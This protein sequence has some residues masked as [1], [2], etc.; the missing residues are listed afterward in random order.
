MDI[1]IGHGQ[2]FVYDQIENLLV[3]LH[4][5]RG[6]QVACDLM[7]LSIPPPLK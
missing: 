6:L 1:Y 5:G 7:Q 3:W 4:D 2:E